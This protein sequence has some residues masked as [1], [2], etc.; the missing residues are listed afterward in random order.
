MTASATVVA[1]QATG[2]SAE[3]VLGSTTIATDTSIAVG[4]SSVS[5]NLNFSAAADL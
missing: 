5:F 4:D 1:G 3:L 2:G